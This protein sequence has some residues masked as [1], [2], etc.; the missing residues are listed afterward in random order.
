MKP[1]DTAYLAAVLGASMAKATSFMTLD[2]RDQMIDVRNIFMQGW[3]GGV[4]DAA[5]A[6]AGLLAERDPD[7]NRDAFLRA[8]GVT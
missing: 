3:Q 2:T 4:A 5:Y 8:C 6:V 7:F 1:A